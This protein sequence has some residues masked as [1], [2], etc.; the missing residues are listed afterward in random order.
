MTSFIASICVWFK[1]FHTLHLSLSN[2]IRDVGDWWLNHY[3][4]AHFSSSFDRSKKKSTNSLRC[5]FMDEKRDFLIFWMVEGNYLQFPKYIIIDIISA[6]FNVFLSRIHTHCTLYA[7]K[8]FLMRLRKRKEIKEE[9][10]I[11]KMPLRNF[12]FTTSYCYFSSHYKSQ[13]RF[14]RVLLAKKSNINST[15]NDRS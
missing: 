13:T 1:I 8:T 14:H 4:W 15:K 12:F 10:F 9:K 3:L 7:I 11:I 5:F 2:I 6:H